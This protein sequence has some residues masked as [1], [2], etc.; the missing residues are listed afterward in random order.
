MRGLMDE[1]T[2]LGKELLLLLA[3]KSFKDIYFK[4]KDP[5]HFVNLKMSKLK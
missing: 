3:N 2:H 5:E 4:R 1:C